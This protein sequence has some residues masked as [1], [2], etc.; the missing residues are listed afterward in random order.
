MVTLDSN[1][2]KISQQIQ[3]FV[4]NNYGEKKNQSDS[5]I[6]KLKQRHYEDT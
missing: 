2:P 3:G 4:L 5:N 1:M 6:S